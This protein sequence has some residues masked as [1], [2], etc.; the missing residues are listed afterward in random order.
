M[1]I[2]G[3]GTESRRHVGQNCESAK[4]QSQL[5]SASAQSRETASAGYAGDHVTLATPF[6]FQ[7]NSVHTVTTR[8]GEICLPLFGFIH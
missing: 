7:M 2:S 4:K 3:R 1:L 8:E 5:S 6:V